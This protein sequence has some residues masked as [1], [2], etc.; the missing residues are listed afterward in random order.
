VR[1][2]SGWIE[3]ALRS[4]GLVSNAEWFRAVAKS[5]AN[6]SARAPYAWTALA[7]PRLESLADALDAAGSLAPLAAAEAGAQA[8]AQAIE[9]CEEPVDPTQWL[10]CE[11]EGERLAVEWD[12]VLEYGL[13]PGGDRTLVVFADGPARAT[14]V[15]DWLH[16]KAS[17]RR[18]DAGR[19]EDQDG[20]VYR[21]L[22]AAD[23]PPLAPLVANP[24]PSEALQP[25]SAAADIH[26]EEPPPGPAVERVLVADDSIV[27]RVFLGRL[28][29]QRGIEVDE[30]ENAAT[31]RALWSERAYDRVFLDADMPDGGAFTIA[32]PGR[33][34]VVVLVKDELERR[35]AL[36]LGF[37]VVLLKPF[38]EDEVARALY[39]RPT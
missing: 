23:V 16:G 2:A 1:A 17:G 28:L 20:H 12:S 5:G 27:A 39:A 26:L 11:R 36:A 4:Y 34:E 3:P 37:D 32:E 31:A 33:P 18:L 24:D 13:E 14:F 10:Y 19:I 8:H 35:H 21:V 7:A 38:A 15:A 30:A 9:T 25:A 29:R 22:R 6:E